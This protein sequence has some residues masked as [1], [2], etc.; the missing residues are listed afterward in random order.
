MVS[1]S[2]FCVSG[3]KRQK[4]KAEKDWLTAVVSKVLLSESLYT[5]YEDPKEFLP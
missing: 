4:W 3:K 5:S 2:Q 1:A